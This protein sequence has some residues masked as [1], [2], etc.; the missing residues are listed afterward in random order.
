MLFSSTLLKA[1]WDTTA[2]QLT[3]GH[4]GTD[5]GSGHELSTGRGS[6]QERSSSTY[7]NAVA[8]STR[9]S[10]LAHGS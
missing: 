8:D 1:L 5:R 6:G 2:E 3:R 4:V 7:T 10:A 9:K